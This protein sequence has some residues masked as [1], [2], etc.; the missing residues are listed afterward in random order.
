MWMKRQ[1]KKIWEIRER[2][3][4]EVKDK[5]EEIE[6]R[7]RG[8]ARGSGEGMDRCK[9][10]GCEGRDVRKC[11]VC[12]DRMCNKCINKHMGRISMKRSEEVRGEVETV[13]HGKGKEQ[14]Y[15]EQGEEIRCGKRWWGRRRECEECGARGMELR[16]CEGCAGIR[17]RICMY[18]QEDQEW[19]EGIG[20]AM[21]ETSRRECWKVYQEA[22]EGKRYHWMEMGWG[23]C[24]NCDKLKRET[25]TSEER[26]YGAQWG[27][28]VECWEGMEMYRCGTCGNKGIGGQ[29]CGTERDYNNIVGKC[30]KKKCGETLCNECWLQHRREDHEERA[31]AS[32]AKVTW[33]MVKEEVEIGEARERIERE[34]RRR[35]EEQGREKGEERGQRTLEEEGEGEGRGAKGGEGRGEGSRDDLTKKGMAKMLHYKEMV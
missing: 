19:S 26:D 34:E 8:K 22:G 13:E 16:T 31:V 23:R 5:T 24:T 4:R 15:W 1:T 11:P 27:L 3:M 20:K 7:T 18:R 6:R 29:R 9:M 28:C 12:E 30:Y 32:G 17:C 35:E 2:W 21:G 33:K 14:L 10:C 25:R